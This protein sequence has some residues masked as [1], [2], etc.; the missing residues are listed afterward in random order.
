[1]TRHLSH[2]TTQVLPAVVIAGLFGL[3]SNDT[4]AAPESTESPVTVE[5][6]SRPQTIQVVGIV[7]DFIER[8]S[9]GGHPDFENR[10]DCGFGHYAGNVALTIGENRKPVFT[11]QGSRVVDQYYDADGRPI[12]YALYD[13]ML[14]DVEG[15]R[16]QSSTGGITSAESFESWY[17]D[18]QGM[19]ISSALSLTLELQP[20]GQYVFD[21]RVDEMYKNM[22]GFFPVDDQHF[23]NSGG[24]PDHN[25]HF[26]VELN[27]AFKYEAEGDQ[28]FKFIG[29]DDVWVFINDQLVIDL[30]GVHSAV[31]QYVDL[32]RLRLEDGEIYPIDFFF[33]ERHRTQSNFRIE[34]NIP[35]QSTRIPSVSAAFD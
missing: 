18:V 7:R 24:S 1:M 10:P 25:F 9:A 27:M 26:T 6:E 8:S 22:G 28:Y 5:G 15:T 30:G 3:L 23:G 4:S 20:D 13:Q 16:S 12:C 21:D 14:G 33:A 11:G 29:D 17:T 32:D 31:E 35:L 19:N 34:T 2:V